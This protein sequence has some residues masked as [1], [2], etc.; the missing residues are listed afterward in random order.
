[1]A[2]SNPRWPHICKIYRMEGVTNFCEG[3]EYVL[4]EGKCRKYGNTS[5]RT[6][7]SNEGVQKA[8]YAL[9]LPGQV[10]GITTGTLID[11]QD[12]TGFIKGA[13]ATDSYPTNLGTTVFFNLPKN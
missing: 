11:V 2:V 8:D 3:K 1:M 6:F 5:I 10:E 13:I 12:L 4:Y 9:S 7:T